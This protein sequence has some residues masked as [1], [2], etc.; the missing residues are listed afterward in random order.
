MVVTRFSRALDAF[1]A[2]S[3]R[4]PT[5]EIVGGE[6]QPR[7]WLQAE[8]LAHWVERLAPEAPEALRLAAHCQHIGRFE[9]PRSSYP[10]GRKGYLRWR[11][12]LSKRH[13]ET[14]RKILSELGYDD[15]T[16]ERVQRIVRKQDL[17]ADPDVQTMEDA[18]CLSFLEHELQEFAGRHEDDKVISILRKT[19]RKMSQHAR[20]AAL[21]LPLDERSAALVAKALAAGSPKP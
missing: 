6:P 7:E 19:W 12:D 13:A 1:A 17:K 9:L 3:R 21:S 15:A 8:R 16:L 14:A 10:E 20:E 11:S 18:L 4:D 5:R 2:V